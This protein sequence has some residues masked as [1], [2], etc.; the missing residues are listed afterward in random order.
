MSRPS[1][2]EYISN[3]WA[4][5]T[6]PVGKTKW[7]GPR[8]WP[9]HIGRIKLPNDGISPNDDYF[10]TTQYYWDTYFNI[11]GLVVDGKT[12]LAKGL[13][14][15]LLYLFPKFGLI[16]ARNSWTSLGRTQ[17]PFLTRMAFEVF[18]HGGA[19]KSWLDKVMQAAL[20][21][22]ETVWMSGQR[23][24]PELGLSRYRPKYFPG[25]LTTYESGWDTSSRF[26]TQGKNIVPVDLNCLLYQYESDFAVWRKMNGDKAG[27]R[28]W[29]SA[30][31]KRR[32]AIDEAFWDSASGFYYDNCDGKTG[33][34]KTLAGFMPLWCGAASQEQ[35]EACL[36]SLKVFLQP[37]GVAM[38]EPI[39]WQGWQWDYP[40]GWPTHNYLVYEALK[41]YGYKKEAKEVSRRWLS[42]N[43]LVYK[44]TGKLWEKYDVVNKKKGLSGRY[45]TPSGFSWTNSVYLRLT[46]NN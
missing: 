21:E 41:K 40:N 4:R 23:Y 8:S 46:K 26:R 33:N 17:P 16:P 39:D 36:N 37:G 20:K 38:T 18:E 29:R 45:P 1:I 44:H 42:C 31:R 15:N 32:K 3:Y 25:R 13:V 12:G 6:I 2:T 10:A 28:R 22:Y 9:L 19:D 43:Q 7:G 14:D 24:I 35:A 30:M 11:L 5:C 34:L 27:E